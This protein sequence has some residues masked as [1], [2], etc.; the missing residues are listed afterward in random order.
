[1]GTLSSLLD[2]SR[3]AL[4]SNQAAVGRGEQERRKP[5]RHRLHAG[6][7]ELGS[8]RVTINGQSLGSGQIQ[9]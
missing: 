7:G 6:D 9:G 4:K 5:G 8:G 3:N 1:M 2:L